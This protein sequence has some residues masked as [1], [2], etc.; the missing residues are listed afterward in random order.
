MQE[1]DRIELRDALSDLIEDYLAEGESPENAASFMIDCLVAH[2]RCLKGALADVPPSPEETL[3]TYDHDHKAWR[4][5][6]EAKISSC[7][8]CG[9]DIRWQTCQ[10]KKGVKNLP[11]A[12]EPEE[13]EGDLYLH[14]HE[15]P[16][17]TANDTPF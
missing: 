15:C 14:F 12:L 11:F 5:V 9:E 3:C 17:P 13:I 10:T 1:A 16:E 2:T 6:G 4:C 7:K 8:R